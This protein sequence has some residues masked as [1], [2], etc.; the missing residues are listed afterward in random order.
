MNI[1]VFVLFLIFSELNVQFIAGDFEYPI[2]MTW[3]DDE[4]LVVEQR[5]TVRKIKNEKPGE[6][7]LDIRDRVT[8]GGEKGLLSIALGPK[9][10]PSENWVFVNYT[11]KKDG[12][13][14]ISG[15]PIDSSTRKPLNSKEVILMEISQPWSNHNGG[16]I[17]FGPDNYLYIGMGDGG[18]G[19]DPRNHGQNK[20]TYLGAMLRIEPTPS[21]INKYK[22]PQENPFYKTEE[23]KKEILHWGL[24]NPWR[25]SFD[26][27]TNELW[28]ADVG[29][30][31][32][33]EIHKSSFEE[34]GINFGWNIMEGKECYNPPKNCLK[35]GLNIPFYVY[36]HKEGSSITGGYV[37]RGKKIE[38]LKGKYIFA[39]YASGLAYA[40]DTKKQNQKME[41]LAMIWNGHEFSGS[42]TSFAEDK[43]GE[44][45]LITHWG[46]IVKL[47]P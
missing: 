26:K 29:Q 14:V 24:R 43:E 8:S 33:E 10:T 13:T 44:I 9:N 16:Y 47:V 32:W 41:K 37:Y 38:K 12:R 45:Y 6:I 42:I 23:T 25:F 40:I 46:T 30:N 2:H 3:L 7:W 28:I 20:S 21:E 19:G 34:T 17:T 5:G 4:V 35:K 11:A 31:K 15:F 36:S 27:E 22:N 39:D 18:A 1:F